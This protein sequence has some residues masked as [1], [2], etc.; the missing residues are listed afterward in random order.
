[1]FS[2]FCGTMPHFWIVHLP[3]I[4]R[5]RLEAVRSGPPT[6]SDLLLNAHH[7]QHPRRIGS[8]GRTRTSNTLSQSQVH[9]HYATSL[10]GA[11]GE[12][13]THHLL[14][15]NQ[16]LYLLSYNGLLKIQA[17][18]ACN[19]LLDLRQ[20][21]LGDALHSKLISTSLCNFDWFIPSG[22]ALG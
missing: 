10:Y 1:M 3:A 21:V 9:Y 14:I 4:T 13:R 19:N 8:D 17:I 11:V 2:T 7:S 22:A 6:A 15:T 5:L 12:D 20:I 16:P 18:F